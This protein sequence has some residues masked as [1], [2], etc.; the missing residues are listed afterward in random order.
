MT[1][2]ALRQP[3]PPRSRVSV[4]DASRERR[5]RDVRCGLS[6]LPKTLPPYLFYDEA[7]STLYEQITDLPEYYLTRTERSILETHAP[8]IVHR[9]R[10]HTKRPLRVIEL[11]AGTAKKTQAVLSAVLDQQPECTYV[12]IDVSGSALEEASV[13]LETAL[14]TLRIEARLGTHEQALAL[15]EPTS[16]AQLVLFIGSSVGNLEDAAASLLFASL[17]RALGPRTW[18]L[19]GTDLRKSPDLLL[20]AYDDREGVTAA[21]NLNLLTRINRELGGHFDLDTFRHVARWNEASS[22]I[23]MHLESQIAQDVWV[24]ALD[25]RASFARGETIH[26]ESSIKYDLPRVDRILSAAA[27]VRE[28]TFMDPEGTFAVHLARARG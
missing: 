19:L 6:S 9:V 16:A 17:H 26:T 7:G 10:A 18:L 24:E 8:A 23:E 5:A 20:P 14:P 11:G 15:I 21:F 28:Q 13:A 25:L 22:R 12:P 2:T 1:A 4:E 3:A 27:F